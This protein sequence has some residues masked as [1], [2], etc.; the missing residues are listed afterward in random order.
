MG[1]RAALATGW[2]TDRQP[3]C[4]LAGPPRP[5]TYRLAGPRAPAGIRGDAEFQ[6]GRLLA[7]SFTRGVRTRVGVTVGTTTTQRMIRRYRRAGFGVRAPFNPVFGGRFVSVRR[8]GRQ[9]LGGF[10]RGG[11]VRTLGV[12]FVPVCE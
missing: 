9:V 5:H 1:L 2:L 4:E 6:R 7:L 8:N 11:V 12:P 3:G 10:A